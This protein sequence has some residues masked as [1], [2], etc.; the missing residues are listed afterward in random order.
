[1]DEMR[2]D[3][4]KLDSNS[5][6]NTEPV[7]SCLDEEFYAALKSLNRKINKLN[8]ELKG[9]KY[10][11]QKMMDLKR[12]MRRLVNQRVDLLRVVFDVKVQRNTKQ[13][14][15]KPSLLMRFYYDL[16]TIVKS[17]IDDRM[18]LNVTELIRRKPQNLT[19]F[20]SGNTKEYGVKFS[21][22]KERI[23]GSA[24]FKDIISYITELMGMN[25]WHSWGIYKIN[26]LYVLEDHGD[27]RILEWHSD[28]VVN[29]V[30]IP[31]TFANNFLGIDAEDNGYEKPPSKV[32]RHNETV[33]NYM[34]L[35]LDDNLYLIERKK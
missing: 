20:P 24:I 6:D 21:A 10:P 11:Y 27:F 33:A 31:R 26:G 9:S 18:E 17:I 19:G 25:T 13:F 23:I 12:E 14:N 16:D 35:E 32:H 1:M 2:L 8:D 28:H 15:K 4:K 29:G 30:Y 34:D 7:E 22:I 3:L 5:T